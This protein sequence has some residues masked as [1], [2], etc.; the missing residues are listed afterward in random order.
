MAYHVLQN[1]QSMKWIGGEKP[2]GN[3]FIHLLQQYKQEI[4]QQGICFLYLIDMP[5][6]LFSVAKSFPDEPH[7]QLVFMAA[8][9][10]TFLLL[11]CIILITEKNREVGRWQ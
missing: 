4:N 10:V 3:C 11:L 2:T 9:E 6:V 1:R 7:D 5:P 8:G